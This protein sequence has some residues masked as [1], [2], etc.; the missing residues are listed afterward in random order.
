M[1]LV[2]IVLK[3]KSID[4]SGGEPSIY[5]NLTELLDFCIKNDIDAGIVSNG[6]KIKADDINK[7]LWTR[8]SI[9]AYID[10]NL[11][12]NNLIDAEKYIRNDIVYGYSY[13]ISEYSPPDW[14]NKCRKFLEVHKRCTYLRFNIDVEMNAD[15]S[16]AL[17][18]RLVDQISKI[19]KMHIKPVIKTYSSDLPCYYGHIGPFL[20]PD[21]NVYRCAGE[22]AG[23]FERVPIADIFHPNDVLKWHGDKKKCDKC[24]NYF[25]NKYI[26]DFIN[27][28]KHKNFV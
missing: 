12:D 27:N 19:D 20:E 2:E 4:I 8:I 25:I 21:G 3:P 13:I 10:Y 26:D 28:E 14:L 18:S 24:H 7:T 5:P 15:K 16:S 23:W 11:P 6:T 17:Y 22:A 9:N 1:S